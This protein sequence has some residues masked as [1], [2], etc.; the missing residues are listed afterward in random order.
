MS[1]LTRFINRISVA[2]MMTADLLATSDAFCAARG[3]SRARV[4][5]LVFNYGKKLD[6]I[7][8][9]A[10]LATRTFERAMTW[11]DANWPEGADRPVPLILYE[12]WQAERRKAGLNDDDKQGGVGE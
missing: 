8:D 2:V 12:D 10:D 9:G 3:M 11:F 5:T 6:L 4:A 1:R 7:A